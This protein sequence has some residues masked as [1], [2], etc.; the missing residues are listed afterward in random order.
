M[1][2]TE[3]TIDAI[4]VRQKSTEQAKFKA[5]EILHGL[6]ELGKRDIARGEEL[7]GHY[8]EL[9]AFIAKSDNL[10]FG[11]IAD[12]FLGLMHAHP[13][14]TGIDMMRIFKKVCKNRYY[15][16]NVTDAKSQVS[17]NEKMS[18]YFGATIIAVLEFAASISRPDSLRV[19]CQNAFCPL[20]AELLLMDQALLASKLI[21]DKNSGRLANAIGALFKSDIPMD[22]LLDSLWKTLDRNI[23]DLTNV[24]TRIPS[25]SFSSQVLRSICIKY[26]SEKNSCDMLATLNGI[27][28]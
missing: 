24:V 26:F 17:L 19:E 16:P 21:E 22:K 6:I 5:V 7:D 20:F 4:I 13:D 18:T 12:L 2:N 8:H 11:D 1:R 10:R 23:Y 27:K 25:S 9:V 15:H 3:K 14:L 28:Q